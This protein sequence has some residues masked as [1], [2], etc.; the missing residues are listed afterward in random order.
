MFISVA[1]IRSIFDKSIPKDFRDDW[2]GARASVAII[3]V[4]RPDDTNICFIKRATRKGD[5]WSG[6]VA[7]PGGRSSGEEDAFTVAERETFEEVDI[8]LP[9]AKCIGRLEPIDV[10]SN[11]NRQSLLLSPV[12]YFLGEEAIDKAKV[13]SPSEVDSVFWVPMTHLFSPKS[14]TTIKYPNPKKGTA[15]PGISFE[16]YIIWGL[17]LRVLR[18]FGEAIGK[19]LPH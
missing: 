10:S 16:D 18:N 4:A 3:L 8:V 9:R 14:R 17:T 19:N 5:P 11:L 6:Q 15:Y 13:A 2:E 12:V 7:L 1:E